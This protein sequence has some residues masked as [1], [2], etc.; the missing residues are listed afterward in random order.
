MIDKNNRK[1]LY[2]IKT[3]KIPDGIAEI[4]DYSLENYKYHADNYNK[5]FLLNNDIKNFYPINY[6]FDLADNA[7]SISSSLEIKTDTSTKIINST[8]FFNDIEK[9]F[10]ETIVDYI[11]R[12]GCFNVNN[13]RNVYFQSVYDKLKIT[14][15][16][17]NIL[18][19][20]LILHGLGFVK[21]NDNIIATFDKMFV[22][23]IEEDKIGPDI[24]L[25]G[26]VGNLKGYF[27][28]DLSLEFHDKLCN[29]KITISN[30][31]NLDIESN[32]ALTLSGDLITDTSNT[33][34]LYKNSVI[35]VMQDID[36]VKYKTKEKYDNK[37]EYI[38]DR[39]KFFAVSKNNYNVN[40]DF[41]L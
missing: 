13:D 33:L 5:I 10:K 17:E 38:Q 18:S 39:I 41:I 16:E 31:Y 15:L 32:N 40:D 12:D 22:K 21:Y 6:K 24:V 34:T 7:I 3:D 9:F 8:S 2:K 11:D 27:F 25:T 4:T 30:F 26:I 1:V 29:K 35:E 28:K 37:E 19:D 14:L 23:E 36:N 20:G